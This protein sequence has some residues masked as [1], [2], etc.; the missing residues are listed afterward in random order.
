MGM[1]YV[2]IQQIVQFTIYKISNNWS[3]SWEG[4]T[5]SIYWYPGSVRKTIWTQSALRFCG[6]EGQK[7]FKSIKRVSIGSQIKGKLLQNA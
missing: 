5:S 2:S 6:N 3:C 1:R 7:D 4:G